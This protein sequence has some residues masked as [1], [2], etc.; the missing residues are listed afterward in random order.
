[1]KTIM[2]VLA[3]E[4]EEDVM[5][6]LVCAQDYPNNDGHVTLM[7]I[8]TR[9]LHYKLRGIDVTVLNFSATE[10]YFIDGISVITPS[11]YDNNLPI[12][13]LLILHAANLRN[14]YR[15]LKKY[16]DR[17]AHF[18]FFFHGHEVMRINH[19]YAKPYPYVK[20]N[21]INSLA[22][23]VYDE[24]KLKIWRQFFIKNNFKIE[25]VF[26]S[27]WMYEIFK[28]NIRIPESLI[29]NKVHITYN[30]VG[31]EFETETYDPAIEKEY[32]FVTVR[33]FLDGAKYAI[34][35]VNQWAA[36]SPR[37]KF[38]VVGKGE[39]FQHYE[40]A[41]NIEWRNQTMTHDEI[42]DILQHSRFALMPTRTDS[43]GLMM[44]EMA[45]F[46]IPV[47]TSDIP[48]CHEVFDGFENVWYLNNEELDR[49]LDDFKSV[50][51]DC[52]KDS[53]YYIANTVEKEV[54][55]INKMEVS[56][57]TIQEYELNILKYIDRI[58][59]KNKIK[60]YLIGGTLLGAVRHKGFIPWDD[61][62]DIAMT[63]TEF[64]RFLQATEKEKHERY[65]L[66]CLQNEPKWSAPLPK[67]IDTYTVLKQNGHREKMDLGIY[68]DV[69]IFDKNPNTMQEVQKWHARLD[70]L[71]KL[72]G[73]CECKSRAKQEKSLV[74]VIKDTVSFLVSKVLSAR[75]VSL[76]IDRES[77]RYHTSSNS[78]AL[79]QAIYH[80]CSWE[81]VTPTQDI[82]GDGCEL[83][84]A[85]GYYSAPERWDEYLHN[86]YG[87]YMQLP[88]VEERITHHNFVV[89]FKEVK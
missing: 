22:Q 86:Q 23:D 17:F 65:R 32:D 40:K 27:N 50:P 85:D 43:Q 73:A 37:S 76:W 6:V 2:L 80:N 88:P 54:E 7:Y 70:F 59:K 64:N 16:G 11:F 55:L 42:V 12:F 26:V 68:V 30:N 31:K 44:C 81:E 18:I 58:C 21:G 47:I 19:D 35:L 78:N 49:S 3:Q 71:Q 48:V 84:F 39:F 67:V 77:S 74:N 63:R 51:N 83:F 72:W 61:D 79:S 1:M 45:A 8:H 87:D 62:I 38:L 57:K 33:S 36:N 53:R 25:F 56:L 75:T 46:G 24:L 69:F 41:E 10:N 29:A 52:L 89:G 13:D 82:L 9:N 15:F 5:K 60:Y 34:D 4:C 66:C 20:K 28:K 14:H